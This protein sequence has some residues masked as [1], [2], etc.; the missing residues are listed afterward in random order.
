MDS[1]AAILVV[2]SGRSG[3]AAARL[4]RRRGDVRRV[5]IHDD[6]EAGRARATGAGFDVWD[7]NWSGVEAVVWSPGIP[8][9]HPLALK[10]QEQGIAL[11]SEVAFAAPDLPPVVAVT[12][13]NGKSTV[14]TLLGALLRA[15]GCSCEV[16][17]NVGAPVADYAR[18]ADAARWDLLVVE[19]SS[20]QLELPLNLQ[21]RAAVLTNLAPDHL[22]RYADLEAYYAT[23]RG[24]LAALPAGAVFVAPSAEIERFDGGA[25]ALPAVDVS[26]WSRSS[27]LN[28][29]HGAS[30]L[31]QAVAVARH[32]GCTD[33]DARQVAVD[34]AGL[35]HRNVDLGVID[36][37]RYVDDSKA[38]NV[39]AS[40]AA[41][42][43][44]ADP[45]VVLLGGAGK[46]EDYAP[47]AM[48]LHGR[49]ARVVGYGAEGARI[50]EVTG[51]DRVAD[52]EA[53]VRRA[54]A[55]AAPGTTILLAPACASFDAFTDFAARGRRFAELAGAV[56]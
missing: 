34:F 10:A 27:A 31:A 47:I 13:T 53:A 6:L 43:G 48:A 52:L 12:G 4:H 42:G 46:G 32:M 45:C 1:S 23:K 40:V 20:Y 56:N 3:L 51:G 24:L 30:N 8:L 17:G 22:D 21:L 33:S 25:E 54:Q 39:A 36:G 41:I 55:L 15:S 37:L 49:S 14:A 38:T 26:D 19:L 5:L 35:P 50:V 7:G 2:G 11:L 9:V 44:V 28:G 18:R 29:E 16:V